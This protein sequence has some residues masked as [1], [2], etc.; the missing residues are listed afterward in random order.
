MKKEMICIVCPVGCHLEI[1]DDLKVTGNQCKRGEVYAKEEMTNPTRVLTTT[2]AIKS[3]ITRRLSVKSEKPIPKEKLFEAMAILNT[4]MLKAPFSLHE[5][6]AENIAN[7]GINI[8]STREI[9]Q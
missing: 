6:V 2:V 7:T 5:I 4:I 3:D 8:I 1:D 9:E